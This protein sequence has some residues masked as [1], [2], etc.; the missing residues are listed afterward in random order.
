[1][2]SLVC[3]V[4]SIMRAKLMK[5]G[6][7]KTKSIIKSENEKI[8]FLKCLRIE[9]LGS[10]DI[11]VWGKVAYIDQKCMSYCLTGRLSRVILL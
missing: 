1:M 4:M 3:L 8:G 2:S 7:L 5:R 10:V 11:L 9:Y 6:D